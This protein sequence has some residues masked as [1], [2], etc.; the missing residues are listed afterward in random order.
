ML[1][2]AWRE[3]IETRVRKAVGTQRKDA[4][5]AADMSSN[6]FRT[7]CR[8]LAV[9]YATQPDIRHQLGRDATKGL[10]KEIARSGLW[11]TMARVQAWAIGCREYLVRAHVDQGGRLRYRPVAPDYIQ[12]RASTDS[13]MDP[14]R[15]QE[16]RMRYNPAT[17]E[18]AW[19]F[20]VLDISDP[21]RP[22]YEV[23]EAESGDEVGADWSSTF[24]ADLVEAPDRY[25][26]RDEDG[27]PVLPYVVYHASRTGDRLWDPY[28]MIE[29]VEGSLNLATGGSFW[30]H[31]LR[32]ASWPQ[33]YAVDAMVAG[34]DIPTSGDAR[35]SEVVMDPAVLLHLTRTE[36]EAQPIVSQFQTAGD[37]EGTQRALESYATRLGQDAGLPQSDVQRLGGT[38]R[39]GYAI[40]MSNEGKRAAQRHFGPQFGP[41]DAQLVALSAMLLNRETGTRYPEKDY[42]V[43]YREIPLSPQELDSRRKHA[44][45]LMDRRLMSD[46]QAYMYLNPGV[47]EVGA[48]EDLDR[49]RGQ[50][51]PQ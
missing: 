4:W 45:E 1:D 42:S 3:D 24:L 34:G 7:I 6:P 31:M 27:A 51:P 37:V 10:V 2:G 21:A 40:A 23:R 18:P 17:K 36:P 43:V 38:A 19:T 32:S 46:V 9:L 13:P 49:I 11:S 20:D 50:E 41:S 28:E 16:L 26:Y 35:R 29:V 39:S 44:I 15:I 48:Q 12:A 14:V 5:G 8:E 47:D 22:I 30:L 25:P 33:R